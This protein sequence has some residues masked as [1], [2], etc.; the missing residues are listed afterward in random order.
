MMP[1]SIKPGS[2]VIFSLRQAGTQERERVLIP[3][4]KAIQGERNMAHGEAKGRREECV[5]V[6]NYGH[7]TRTPQHSQNTQH[8][9][10]NQTPLKSWISEMFTPRL[11]AKTCLFK[12][13]STL[14]CWW[15]VDNVENRPFFFL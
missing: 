12:R 9:N 8:P 14:V 6:S 5:Y 7:P 4:L 2:V 13:Q 11:G 3:S 15:P 1:S 10:K